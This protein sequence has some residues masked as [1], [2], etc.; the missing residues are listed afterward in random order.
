ML[1]TRPIYNIILN[2]NIILVVYIASVVSRAVSNLLFNH[3]S[4]FVRVHR[5]SEFIGRYYIFRESIFR[6]DDPHSNTNYYYYYYYHYIKARSFISRF[7]IPAHVARSVMS[8]E[9]TVR[10]RC[11]H[12]IIIIITYVIIRGSYS[13]TFVF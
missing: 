9:T 13:K 2:I 4:I 3:S 11:C 5:K 10:H 6:P 8:D 12:L 7:G 1:C